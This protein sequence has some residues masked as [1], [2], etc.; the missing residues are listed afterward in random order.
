MAD[1]LIKIAKKDLSRR[2]RASQDVIKVLLVE[3]I[4][5]IGSGSG[6]RETAEPASRG[7]HIMV[8]TED[9]ERYELPRSPKARAAGSL[10]YRLTLGVGEKLY[11]YVG[12][13]EQVTFCGETAPAH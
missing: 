12:T 5:T 4:I 11:E 6:C 3:R 8:V 10:A 1:K 2:L 9:D 7:D 13:G